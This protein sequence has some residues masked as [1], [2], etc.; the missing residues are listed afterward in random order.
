MLAVKPGTLQ[1]DESCQTLNPKDHV[2]EEPKTPKED[3]G[4]KLQTL[5]RRSEKP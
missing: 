5:N 2:V 3:G 4:E 1:E